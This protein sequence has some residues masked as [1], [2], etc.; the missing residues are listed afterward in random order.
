VDTVKMAGAAQ[1]LRLHTVRTEGGMELVD[2]P[3]APLPDP[4]TPAP[5]RMLPTFDAILLVHVR[6]TQILPEAYRSLVFNTKMPQSIGTFLVDGQVAGSWKVARVGSTATLTYVPF[7][8]LSRAADEDVRDEATGLVRF[9]EPDA[10]SH[11]V[12]RGRAM[13]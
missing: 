7:E 1:R 8:R 13:G 12:K 11:R 4:D 9:M 10:A 6:R 2:L 5:V 3:R